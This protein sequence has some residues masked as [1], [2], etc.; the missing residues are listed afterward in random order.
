MAECE[1]I[2]AEIRGIGAAQDRTLSNCR[3]TARWIKQ[4]AVMVGEEDPQR[5]AWAKKV[6]ARVEQDLTEK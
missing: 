4:S 6:V 5:D 3:M 1:R 2:G